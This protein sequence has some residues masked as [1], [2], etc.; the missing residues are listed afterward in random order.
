MVVRSVVGSLGEARHQAE[1]PLPD[2][3]EGEAAAPEEAQPEANAAIFSPPA[4][5]QKEMQP[6]PETGI[7]PAGTVL[8]ARLVE[9]ISTR[10]HRAGDELVAILDQD[11]KVNGEAAF[12][13]GT[14][15]CG[16]LLAAKGSGWVEGRAETTITLTELCPREEDYRAKTEIASSSRRY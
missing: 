7:V 8:K 4:D 6:E 1:Q 16:T 10:T 3:T 12:S 14:K 9:P 15:V 13:Q 2:Q 5:R 11:L